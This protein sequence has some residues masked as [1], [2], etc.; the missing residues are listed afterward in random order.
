[1]RYRILL[2][3]CLL[4]PGYVLADTW[5]GMPSKIPG[6]ELLSLGRD[7]RGAYVGLLDGESKE[8]LTHCTRG[9]L[10]HVSGFTAP[11]KCQMGEINTHGG[12]FEISLLTKEP[13]RGSGP[14]VMSKQ[15]IPPRMQLFDFSTEESEMLKTADRRSLSALDKSAF[16]CFQKRYK[17]MEDSTA[18]IDRQFGRPVT[19]RTTTF[20]QDH[21][22]YVRDIK[23]RAQYKKF[24]GK[25]FK[26]TGPNGFLYISSIG[27][28]SCDFIGWNIVN[29]VYAQAND[30]LVQVTGFYGCIVGGFR[31]LNGDGVPEVLTH[32]CE[33]GESSETSYW[34]IHPQAKVLLQTM[35]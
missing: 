31:D 19:T 12:V 32:T 22:K 26:I 23:S 15:P 6:V 24:I 14:F 1:M 20:K 5:S 11:V 27:L 35:Y 3:A 33:N 25:K 4:W 30:A 13:L 9:G 18:K 7:D 10:V 2:I 17:E 21:E 8:F 29:V 28:E 16:N 34:T